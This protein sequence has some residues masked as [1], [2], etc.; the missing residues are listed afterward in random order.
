MKTKTILIIFLATMMF[1]AF[2]VCTISCSEREKRVVKLRDTIGFEYFTDRWHQLLLAE[3][4]S[5]E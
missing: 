5:P 4:R 1:G 3:S 2:V